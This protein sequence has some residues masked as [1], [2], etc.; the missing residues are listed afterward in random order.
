LI[1]VARRLSRSKSAT[2][3]SLFLSFSLSLAPCHPCSLLGCNNGI[4][5]FHKNLNFSGTKAARF[6]I[7][8]WR[9]CVGCLKLL[10][11][12]C[13]RAT[14]YR[15]LLR[16]MT[17]KD[18]ASYG[19]SPPCSSKDALQKMQFLGTIKKLA[20]LVPLRQNAK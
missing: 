4:G 7:T 1:F 15:A 18:K 17:C 5:G 2:G 9:K 19:S 12:F 20:S 16:K 8:G 10:V 11:I 6:L 14:N 13:K 3:L